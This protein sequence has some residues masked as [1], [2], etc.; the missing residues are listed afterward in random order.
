VIV[1]LSELHGAP[2]V[3]E[4][5][6]QG[7]IK[8]ARLI[9]H[10]PEA[11]EPMGA[12]ELDPFDAAWVGLRRMVRHVRQFPTFQAALQFYRLGN[13][14]LEDIAVARIVRELVKVEAMPSEPWPGV[15]TDVV[16]HL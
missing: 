1:V 7:L 16:R 14:G 4:V 2:R 3:F 12:K 6:R 11:N 9:Q 8:L 10:G 13:H 5:D 15:N